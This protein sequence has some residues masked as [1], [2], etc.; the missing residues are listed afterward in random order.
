MVLIPIAIGIGPFFVYTYMVKYILY[1]HLWLAV[2]ALLLTME[3]VLF[4]SIPIEYYPFACFSATATLFTYNAHTLFVL[5]SKKKTTELTS[6]AGK[7]YNTVLFAALAGFT[8]S[9]YI[10]IRYFSLSQWSVLIAGGCVWLVYEKVIA[11]VNKNGTVA[12]QNYSF[13]KSIILALVWTVITGVLPLTTSTFGLVL[14]ADTI[15]FICIRFCLFA[16][17][18]QLF[19]YRDL[20]TENKNS[21]VRNMTGKTGGYTNLTLLCN[22]FIAVICIQLLFVNVHVSFKL[23]TALQIL[24][25]LFFIRIKNITTITPSMLLWDGILILSPIISIPLQI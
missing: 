25:L 13:L 17:I 12:V 1:L 22:L 6:W 19:E 16:F 2:I 5:H 7:H 3:S 9:I 15:L 4:F 23:A 14:K 21:K 11:G 18:A 20:H 8:G 10:C 24:F